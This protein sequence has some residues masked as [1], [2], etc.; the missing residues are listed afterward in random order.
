MAPWY[1]MDRDSMALNGIPETELL[2]LEPQVFQIR[3]AGSGY[4]VKLYETPSLGL[5]DSADPT[6]RLPAK[7]FSKVLETALRG[8][9]DKAAIKVGESHD[10]QNWL[11]RF[12]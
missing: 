1:W 7:A 9:F 10:D 11:C 6:E 8:K 4:L 2:E 12:C 5:W 3:E